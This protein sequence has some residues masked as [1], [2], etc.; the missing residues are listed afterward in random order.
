MKKHLIIVL[1]IFAQISCA[2]NSEKSEKINNENKTDIEY[3]RNYTISLINLISTPEKYHGKKVQIIG[4]I[5]LDF[6][7]NGI[8]LNKDD[9]EYAIYSNGFSFSLPEGILKN[10][11]NKFD[12][13]YVLLA[14][15]FNMNQKGKVG[16]WSGKL[17]N[18]TRMIG[19]GNKT[20]HSN[21]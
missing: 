10:S 20:N 12:K 5:S 8:Y 14:G 21:D 9:Y 3:T 16:P 6:E 4:Y 17:E 2:Q 13:S 1:L 11:G 15:T 18:I 19:I 7:K